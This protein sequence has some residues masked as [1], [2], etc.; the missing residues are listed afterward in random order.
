MALSGSHPDSV[1]CLPEEPA[2]ARLFRNFFDD[3]YYF[4]SAKALAQGGGYI[5]P[6]LPG[7][8]PQTKYPV[9]Y[10]WLLSW[11]WRW[12]PSFPSNILALNAGLMLTW[13]WVSTDRFTLPFLP[14][15][16]MGLW[17]E[18]K[19]LVRVLSASW[20]ARAANGVKEHPGARC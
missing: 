7:G 20:I 9:L 11:V 1:P 18:G 4:G 2:S 13:N 12:Y 3:A 10:P 17:L 5:I 16:C 15:F 19:H 6:N 14:L 8:P